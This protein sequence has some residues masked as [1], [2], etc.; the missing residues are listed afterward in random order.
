MTKDVDGQVED[1]E[2]GDEDDQDP[3]TV[4]QVIQQLKEIIN[5]ELET[6][7]RGAKGS[8]LQTVNFKAAVFSRI[9]ELDAPDSKQ[10]LFVMLWLVPLTFCR[11]GEGGTTAGASWSSWRARTG[12]SR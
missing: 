3:D 6:P 9:L 10:T 7:P 1:G 8:K 4:D 12:R 11:K 5:E 2:D